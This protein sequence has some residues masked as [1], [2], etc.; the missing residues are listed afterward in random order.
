MIQQVQVW[1]E[2]TGVRLCRKAFPPPGPQVHGSGVDGAPSPQQGTVA[3]D[4]V[5]SL[6]KQRLQRREKVSG[7]SKELLH[8]GSLLFSLC[9]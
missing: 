8:M 9:F 4:A 2:R 5:N 7:G 1:S 6:H 3:E